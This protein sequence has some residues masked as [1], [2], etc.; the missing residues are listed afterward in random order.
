MGGSMD[1]ETRQKTW[2]EPSVARMEA[3]AAPLTP[4]LAEAVPLRAENA[5]EIPDYLREVYSWAYLHPTFA[6]L[7]DRQPVVEAILWGN[8]RRL[9]A[10]VLAEVEPGWRVLQP[11]AVYGTFSRQLA[12][13]L[14]PTGRLD[15]SDIAPLQVALTRR[16]LAGLRQARVDLRDAAEP[17]RSRYDA[18]TCFFL[19]HEV[20]DAMKSRIVAALLGA[21]RPGGKAVF[22]D[23][24]RPRRTHLL[25]PV[26]DLIFARL[27]PFA[28]ALWHRAIADYAGPL[29]AGFEWRKE[30]LFGDLYQVVVATRR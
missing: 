15:V 6:L 26:M 2:L 30:T 13:A 8:A 1:G 11:A 20:P 5:Q 17:R 21:V 28:R 25:R 4:L 19:L 23:Y 27:E 18:V 10:R 14:G 29:G 22:V 12:M 16:K 7:L 9:I 24:H 3:A